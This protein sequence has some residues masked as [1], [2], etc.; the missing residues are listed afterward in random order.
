MQ[1]L[2]HLCACGFAAKRAPL[3]KERRGALYTVADEFTLFSLKWMQDH[4]RQAG[5]SGVYTQSIANSPAYR[6]WCGFAFEMLCLKH[7]EQV[8][9]ALGLHKIA[10]TP[11]VFYACDP[12]TGSR[13]AQVDLLFD[14]ADRTITLC[15][16]KYTDGEYT[17]TKADRDAIRSR[18][19]AIRAYLRTQRVADRSIVV[20][21]ITPYGL[22]R[23]GHFNELHPDVV[24]LQD[25]VGPASMARA[26]DGD[27]YGGWRSIPA[28]VLR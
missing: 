11:G 3:F 15:E 14:R 20:A 24:R 28:R 2:T 22:T 25:I 6:S 17:I 4:R 9:A 19:A 23:N 18:K 7:H 26:T 27:R 16:I 5:A 1:I 13:T 8:R 21:F 10:A 12:A